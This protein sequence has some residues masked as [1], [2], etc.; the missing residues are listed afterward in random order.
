MSVSFSRRLPLYVLICTTILGIALF[1]WPEQ[2]RRWLSG[3]LGIVELPTIAFALWG[4]WEAARI[5][6]DRRK[7][8]YPHLAWWFGLFAIALFVFAGEE[9]S[10]GQSWFH[11]ATPEDY[12]RINRQGETNLHNLSSLTE[13]IPKTLLIAAALVGGIIWPIWAWAKKRGPYLGQGWFSWIWPSSLIWPAAALTWVMRISERLLVATD[14]EDMF[15]PQYIAI[16]ES[17]EIYAVLFILAYLWDV[18]RRMDAG[19]PA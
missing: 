18:R 14:M 15:R 2:G 17:I 12:A 19:Q 11:W 9:A 1:P 5:V 4:V 6:R 13:E 16:R 3:E 10:W 7:L 8:P